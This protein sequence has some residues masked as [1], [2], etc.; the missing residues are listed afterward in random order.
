MLPQYGYG[1]RFIWIWIHRIFYKSG[2]G[3]SR[4]MKRR[5]IDKNVFIMNK[6][7]KTINETR[8]YNYNLFPEQ[9][10]FMHITINND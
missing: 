7:I 9:R 10:I 6:K 1:S 2:F 8:E 3:Y 4:E 5:K